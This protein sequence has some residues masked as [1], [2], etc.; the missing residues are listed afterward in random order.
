MRPLCKSFPLLS[1]PTSL[2]FFLRINSKPS[3]IRNNR[4][5]IM[6]RAQDMYPENGTAQHQHQHQHRQRQQQQ[7]ASSSSS[8]SLVPVT[9][10]STGPGS[11]SESPDF[12]QQYFAN[13]HVHPTLPISG[14]A[15]HLP[16]SYAGMSRYPSSSHLLG[17]S[18]DTIYTQAASSAPT[19]IHDNPNKHA[20]RLETVSHEREKPFEEPE[21]PV[22]SSSSSSRAKMD[23]GEIYAAVYSGIPVYEMM[24]NGVA[25]MRRKSDGYLN[26]TQILKV[27]GVEKG[28]RTKILDKEVMTGQHEKVQGGYGKYQGTWIPYERA[29]LLAKMYGVDGHLGPLFDFQ[30][31]PPGRPDQTPTKEQVYAAHKESASKGGA[32]SRKGKSQNHSNDADTP[33]PT[34]RKARVGRPPKRPVA[35]IGLDD[36]DV[37]GTS[38]T[39]PSASHA[40]KKACT[41]TPPAMYM[42]TSAEQ[43]RAMLMAMFVHEDPLYIP[44]MLSGHSLPPDL[45]LDIVIDEQGH[46]ALH[47]AAALARINV[48][49]V[50]LQKGAT[51]TAMN[52]DGESAL[53]RAVR[54]TNNYDSQT[55][56]E[57][58]ALLH[59]ILP[60]SDSKQ[61]TVMHHIAMTA[62]LDGRIAASKY[63]ME[64]VLEWIARH[65]GD[66]ASLVDV[67]DNAG[68]TA[69]CIAA[70]IG[71]RCLVEQLIDAGADPEIAN[72]AGLRPADFGFEEIID[73]VKNESRDS[74]EKGNGSSR[75]VFPSIR[76]D[77][78]DMELALNAVVGVTKGKEIASAVQQMVDDMSSSFSTEMKAK[79]DQLAETRS[80]LCEVTRELAEVRKQNNLLRKENA[81]LPD[82]IQRIKNLESCLAEEMAKAIGRASDKDAPFAAHPL[83]GVAP[84]A[85]NATDLASLE[86]ELAAL[87]QSLRAKEAMEASLHSQIIKLRSSTDKSELGCKKI[88]A[89]CLGVPIENVDD[90]LTPLLQAIESDGGELDM[91]ALAAF[92]SSVKRREAGV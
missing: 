3:S 50:L 23:E 25:V 45:D 64:G 68:D 36:D 13:V 15:S 89:A 60:M 65:G 83:D 7:L 54:V 75:V 71:N 63:Y 27:A 49:R 90:L 80:Q 51:I 11:S 46:T 74:G 6:I 57:L 41:A 58:I 24:A 86:A 87:R 39:T 70:R 26:A 4:P 62:G 73:Q 19:P 47:W 61:R 91:N 53:I 76:T 84:A 40:K 1:T 9:Y 38:P 28:K 59:P 10:N 8:P 52:N 32:S 14:P 2:L 35:D 82:L 69:L 48:V 12:F 30:L 22:P 34:K 44:E 37:P 5:N 67:Q 56:P 17:V 16:S 92:M 20:S 77:E 66:F 55:F 72:K 78:E 43:Y 21:P 33:A 18:P 81:M 85:G 79:A 42:D 29:I 31:P 88:I